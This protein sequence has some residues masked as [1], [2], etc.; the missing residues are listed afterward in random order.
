VI[1][2]KRINWK[3]KK[4]LMLSTTS[5]LQSSDTH[6]ILHR[7]NTSEPPQSTKMALW[8]EKLPDPSDKF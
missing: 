1:I 6:L 2:A 7:K 3:K 5:K 4:R 8:A